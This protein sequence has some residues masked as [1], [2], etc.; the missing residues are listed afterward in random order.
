MTRKH[1]K[2]QLAFSWF[3]VLIVLLWVSVFLLFYHSCKN[4]GKRAQSTS[5]QNARIDSSVNHPKPVR[6]EGNNFQ[7]L[8]TNTSRLLADFRAR[9]SD[10]KDGCLSMCYDVEI[11]PHEWLR[12]LARSWSI[13]GIS[14]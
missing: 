11:N 4:S 12:C 10:V 5:S 9:V 13:T 14:H 2:Q 6:R 1:W 8:A 3:I 7:R